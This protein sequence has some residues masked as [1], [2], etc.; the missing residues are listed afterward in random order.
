MTEQMFTVVGARGGSGATTISAAVALD[1][2]RVAATE[3]VAADMDTAAALLGIGV[4]QDQS[5]QIEVADG[6]TFV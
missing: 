6:L 2:S 1:A 5:A 3:L 4:A